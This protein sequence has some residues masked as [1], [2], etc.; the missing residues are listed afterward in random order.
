MGTMTQA[1]EDRAVRL[2]AVEKRL[3]SFEDRLSRWDNVE[4]Q[5][6]RALEQ[7]S[8][9]QGTVEALRADFDRM[10]ALAEQTVTSVRE[11]TAAAREVEESRKL[12]AD[13]QGR[14]GEIKDTAKALDERK[15]QMVKAEER[16]ARA[17]ALL[18]DVRSGVEALE[19][20][21]AIVDQAVE[22]TS[23]L[24]FLLKQA[25]A[26]ISGL[27]EERELTSRVLPSGAGASSTGSSSTRSS[28][29]RKSDPSPFAPPED[30][31]EAYA[32]PHI[33]DADDYAETTLADDEPQAKAA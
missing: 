25:D 24:R 7:L 10:F 28:R 1:L 27:R 15:R 8:V 30:A 9:R 11:I 22:K 16:L 5:L 20:Q 29:R 17:E 31:V 12:L 19:G 6:E 4:K 32:T 18:V 14:L 33:D 3:H 23:Q 2:Q 21:K 26:T 13:V